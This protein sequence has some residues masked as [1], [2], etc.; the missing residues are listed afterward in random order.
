[1]GL[2]SRAADVGAVDETRHDAQVLG[3]RDGGQLP[4]PRH[5]P[6]PGREQAVDLAHRD[7]GVGQRVARR[8]CLQLQHRHRRQHLAVFQRDVGDTD[9]H[10]FR[11]AH[12]PR[13]P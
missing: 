8:Q 7:A 10:G 5:S 11:F 1:M 3:Q 13:T 2:E 12:Q 4:R 6:H 9:D